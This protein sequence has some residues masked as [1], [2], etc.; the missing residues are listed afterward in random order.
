V[1]EEIRKVELLADKQDHFITSRKVKIYW[2]LQIY[3]N[4]PLAVV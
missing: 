3:T 1:G 4:I 2:E